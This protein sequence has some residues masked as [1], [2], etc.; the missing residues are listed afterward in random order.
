MGVINIIEGSYIPHHCQLPSPN[1]HALGTLV[2][3]DI[4]YLWW[5]NNDYSYLSSQAYLWVRVR[6][7]NFKARARIRENI[8][9]AFMLNLKTDL[10][11]T[12]R[13]HQLWNERVDA[14]TKH[15]DK[16]PKPPKF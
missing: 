6:W 11:N 16:L 7:Y 4:C 1:D 8:Y 3:C 9:D 10:D 15:I 14:L 2:Q 13:D 5:M 12:I